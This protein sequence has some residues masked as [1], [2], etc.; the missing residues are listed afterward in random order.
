[1]T[2]PR[3][4]DRRSTRRLPLAPVPK[5][6]RADSVMVRTGCLPDRPVVPTWK[7]YMAILVAIAGGA[8][9]ARDSE[10][11][12]PLAAFVLLAVVA[13]MAMLAIVA[14]AALLRLRLLLTAPHPAGMA[15]AARRTTTAALPRGAG[16]RAARPRC[17]AGRAACSAARRLGTRVRDQLLGRPATSITTAVA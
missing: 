8:H 6:G 15:H 7:T 1:M 3:T 14:V 2:K 4:L 5:S 13:I 9:S 10:A 12:V 11:R 17:T 16:P